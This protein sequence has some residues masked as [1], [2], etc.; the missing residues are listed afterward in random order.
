M[1]NKKIIIWLIVI[2]LLIASFYFVSYRSY[3]PIYKATAT[4]DF[5]S[6]AAGTAS[7]LTATVTGA[8]AGDAVIIGAPDGSMLTN[9]Q[10][11]G[12]ISAPNTAT[13]RFLNGNLITALN[14]AS[15]AFKIVVI[16]VR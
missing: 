15:G 16:P 2:A 8:V 11:F 3:D 6:T 4:L 1:Q 10:Y 13:V 14:P 5:A 12:W 7:D 9:G